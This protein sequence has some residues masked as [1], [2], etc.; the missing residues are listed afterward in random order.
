MTNY[1]FYGLIIAVVNFVYTLIL[2]FLGFHGEKMAQ[3]QALGYVGILIGVIGLFLAIREC[4][5]DVLEE[6]RDFTW[7]SGFKVSFMTNLFASIG[8]AIF[9]FIYMSY[10]NPEFVDAIVNMQADKMIEKGAAEEMLQ[11]MEKGTRMMLKP[12]PYSIMAFVG[13]IFFGTILSLIIP[14]FTRKKAEG[15]AEAV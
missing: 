12:I 6:P 4:R 8:G 14:L 5:K 3:G 13:S 11:Q 9:T 7:G 10:I 15:Q 1:I 2:Y